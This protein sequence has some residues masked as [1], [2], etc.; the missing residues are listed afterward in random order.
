MRDAGVG[1]RWGG[2]RETM[3]VQLHTTHSSSSLR[4]API[5]TPPHIDIGIGRL[6]LIPR[7]RRE[8]E[9]RPERGLTAPSWSVGSKQSSQV[10]M[11]LSNGQPHLIIKYF[12]YIVR[13]FHYYVR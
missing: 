10:R 13:Y 7:A 2:E 11:L 4:R 5:S 8:V 12:H 9:A 1:A 6:V 3:V